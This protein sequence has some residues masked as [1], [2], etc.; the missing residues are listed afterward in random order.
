MA[1]TRTAAKRNDNHNAASIKVERIAV[2]ADAKLFINREVSLLEFFR[3]VLEE[4]QDESNPLLERS[5]F[6]SIVGSNLAEF[7]MVRIAGIKQQIEAGVI[8]LTPDGLTPAEELAI[9]RPIALDIMNRARDCLQSLLFQLNQ[10]GV[11]ILDYAALSAEQKASVDAYFAE[12]IFPVLTPLASDPSRP[13]PHI[14]N[15]SMNLAVVIRDEN[16]GERFARDRQAIPPAAHRAR[17]WL[18]APRVCALPL[19]F[20]RSV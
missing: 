15:M 13:F 7:F 5:K 12:M 19:S 14:S 2:P 6:L 10:A 17:A 18:R 8:D 3:R 1:K 16:G 4:A 9:L 20:A 11:H